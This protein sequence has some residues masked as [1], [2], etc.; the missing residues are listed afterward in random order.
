ML[1][2]LGYEL[3]TT[4][5]AAELVVTKDGTKFVA[6]LASPANLAP[7]ALRDLTRLHS[8]VVAASAAAGIFITARG[9][10]PEAEAY[11]STAP[12]KLVN[13]PKLVASIRRSLE[14]A[15]M[16]EDYRAM[17]RQ[18]G[19]IVKHTLDR[20]EAVSCR[21]AHPVA[22][23]IARAALVPTQAEGSST[24]Y[25]PPRQFSRYEVRAHNA[26]YQAKRRRLRPKPA[27]D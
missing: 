12:L 3:V 10:T 6:A 11:A 13:G 24:A 14:G 21:N 2:H 8:V 15:T 9:F 27:H 23:S 7:T 16:P 1:E 5:S 17:C 20:A 25:T 22:P 19:D 18:C 26:K 4:E